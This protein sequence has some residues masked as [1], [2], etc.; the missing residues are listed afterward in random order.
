MSE[1][2]RKKKKRNLYP[3][4]PVE[5]FN[6]FQNFGYCNRNRFSLDSGLLKAIDPG[7]LRAIDP[8]LLKGLLIVII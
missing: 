2:S 8:G 1:V 6:E 7:L 5:N 4:L 3:F